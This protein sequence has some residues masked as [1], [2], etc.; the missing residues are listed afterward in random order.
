MSTGFSL[1]VI[2]GT[3]GSLIVFTLLLVMNRKVKSPGQTTGHVYDGIEEYDNPMPAWWFWGFLLSI[4]FALAY[5]IYYPG[6]GNFAGLGGWTSVG[7]L[8]A[9]QRAAD[10]RYGPLFAQYRAVPVDELMNNQAAMRMGQRLFANNCAQCHGAAGTGSM[11]FPNLTDGEWQW[12]G[13]AE[14]IHATLMNGRLAAMPGWSNVLD[15][16]GIRDVTEFVVQMSGREANTQ[17]ATAGQNLYGQFCA[18]CH[19][20]D[21]RGQVLLGA[22]DLT[23]DTWLYGGRREQI[24]DVLR[25]GR[26]GVMPGFADKLGEDRV[27]ILNA[28][29]K[30]LAH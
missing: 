4:L 2:L 14:Q 10:E 22:P 21:G 11:G 6:L 27:H 9:Q 20:M 15:E 26:N 24:A 3:L 19:G 28:Y 29:V 30:S 13:S 12:G 17:Q 16:Y 1:F 7:A 23:N 8:Q 25:N 5:L 18:A